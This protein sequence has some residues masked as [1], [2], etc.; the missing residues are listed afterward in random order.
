MLTNEILIESVSKILGH[1]SIRIARHY[2]RVTDRKVN[3]D[4]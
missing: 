3:D 2:T 4:T 1:K